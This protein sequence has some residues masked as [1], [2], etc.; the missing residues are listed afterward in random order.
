MIA[1]HVAESHLRILPAAAAYLLRILP[2]DA[3]NGA[4]VSAPNLAAYPLRMEIACL[5]TRQNKIHPSFGASFGA[6]SGPS[7]GGMFRGIFR[8]HLGVGGPR[9]R[10]PKW[11]SYSL[12]F[13][14]PTWGSTV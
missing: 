6:S 4:R 13:W 5:K 11:T 12:V 7:F 10:N 14:T 9:S 3:P 8:G 1:P 2:L